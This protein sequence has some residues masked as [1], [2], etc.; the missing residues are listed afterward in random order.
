MI[1]LHAASRFSRNGSRAPEPFFTFD[2]ACSYAVKYS[3][4]VG[5]ESYKPEV[6]VRDSAPDQST[7]VL[8]KHGESALWD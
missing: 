3:R 7:L 2:R 6:F 4:L 5:T 8:R 1:F